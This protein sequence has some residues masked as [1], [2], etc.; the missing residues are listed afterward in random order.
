[1]PE[2]GPSGGGNDRASKDFLNRDKGLVT[3]ILFSISFFPSKNNLLNVDIDDVQ[4]HLYICMRRNFI[5][6]WSMN[7]VSKRVQL[8]KLGKKKYFFFSFGKPVQ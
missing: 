7:K 5:L 6:I 2:L 3:Y 8:T 1:M 4:I